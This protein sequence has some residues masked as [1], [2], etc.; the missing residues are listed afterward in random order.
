MTY[1][2]IL[3]RM[4]SRVPDTFDKREGSVI[5]DAIAPSA[6]ECFLLY[7][8]IEQKRKNTFAGTADREGLIERGAEIGIAPFEATYALRK[9]IFT[10]FTLEVNIG[11]RF[12]YEDLNF[13]VV[14]KLE[15]GV[16]SLKC[17]TVG[18]VGNL[19]S[20]NLIPID[21]IGGLET[22]TLS[23]EVLIYGEDEEE[24]ES[25]RKRYFATLPT[26]T[27]DGNIAQY[28]KWMTEYEG[29]GN[30]K[31]FPLWNGK[32]TVKVS[33]LS[34]ENTIASQTLIDDVQEYL[35]PNSEGLGNGKAPIGAIVTVSTAQE[36]NI[37]INA[38]V[39]LRVGFDAPVGLEES[40]NEY[41]KTL[42]YY[43]NSV[44]YIALGAIFA[45]NDS[46][47]LVT[48]MTLNGGKVDVTLPDESIAKLNTLNIEVV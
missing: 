15:D 30:F 22:A 25:F 18:S 37:D 9:G 45:N 31:V 13:V 1:E 2:K 7:Q 29:V 46:I 5:Y 32:N 10:P 39:V 12:S 26:M 19:G 47:E 40:I 34:A 16:Y 8:D 17:E 27:L 42:N 6:Y 24:T 38:T 14:E 36:V 48:N 20:G 28:N 23:G 4:L 33:I 3:E 21:Y 44:S 43:R 11:E 41:L 35:D